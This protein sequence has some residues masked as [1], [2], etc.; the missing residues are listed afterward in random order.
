[1][2]REERASVLGGQYTYAPQPHLKVQTAETHIQQNAAARA[3]AR[4][5]V[6]VDTLTHAPF[7][8]TGRGQVL[9]LVKDL[10]LKVF[11]ALR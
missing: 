8:R 4:S 7:K 5:K 1:M 10:T 3:K 2:Q 6:H 9:Y 11:A